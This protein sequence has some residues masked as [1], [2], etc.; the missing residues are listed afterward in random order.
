MN[1]LEK[2]IQ[3]ISKVMKYDRKDVD[4]FVKAG[5]NYRDNVNEL[6]EAIFMYM[7]SCMLG[8]EIDKEIYL[9]EIENLI[10]VREHEKIIKI[11]NEEV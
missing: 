8:N 6:N 10:G 9:D 3:N 2:V 5:I 1:N 4:A 11:I 7:E